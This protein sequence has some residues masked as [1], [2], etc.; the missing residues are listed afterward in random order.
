VT[1]ILRDAFMTERNSANRE[2]V[3][4]AFP[5]MEPGEGWVQTNG[6]GRAFGHL[7]RSRARHLN[8]PGIVP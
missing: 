5:V 3:F 6:S 1:R 8:A 2:R 4:N 7:R